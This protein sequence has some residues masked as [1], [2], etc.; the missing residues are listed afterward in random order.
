[1]ID[2]EPQIRRFVS[3]GLELYGYSIR[4][5]E[6]GAAGMNVVAR[7]RPDLIIVD[8]A[9]P[10]INGLEV[11]NTVRSWSNV[12]VIV[13]S[14]E[15]DE[16]QKVHLLRSGADD[17]V[18]DKKP[19]VKTGS[20]TIDLEARSAT[21]NGQHVSL[22]R[23]EYHL[24]H[25]LASHVGL[26]ITHSHLIKD[27]WGNFRNEQLRL[28]RIGL[29]LLMPGCRSQVSH[30]HAQILDVIG[31]GNLAWVIAWWAT[32]PQDQAGKRRAFG[33]ASRHTPIVGI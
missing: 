27:L 20:L 30:Q 16:E 33:R 25:L 29:E 10:D 1:V 9:L 26:V 11:L 13:L 7:T 31:R 6:T 5:A 12:P 15:A 18:T 2:D 28:A 23:K 21:L 19:V 4:E 3:A 22:T 24:L 32:G 14:I 8:L 17:Y